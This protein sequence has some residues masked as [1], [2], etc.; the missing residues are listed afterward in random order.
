MFYRSTVNNNTLQGKTQ[1]LG[2][3]IQRGEEFTEGRRNQANLGAFD[4]KAN[5]I[6]AFAQK[7]SS[8]KI[9]I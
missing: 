1:F 7:S 6:K 5:F 9:D 2:I 4:A 8:K 3:V